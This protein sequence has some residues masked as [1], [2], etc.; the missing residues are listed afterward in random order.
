M[1]AAAAGSGNDDDGGGGGGGGGGATVAA[2][3]AAPGGDEYA[4]A[5]L[6]RHV[7]RAAAPGG[8]ET[9]GVAHVAA[10]GVLARVA[11]ALVLACGEGGRRR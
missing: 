10:I 7:R 5:S 9:L 3:D 6:V 2:V 8:G 11:F 4:L 1:R